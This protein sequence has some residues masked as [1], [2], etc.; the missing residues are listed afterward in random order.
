MCD[1]LD[2]NSEADWASRRTVRSL[3]STRRH[4]IEEAG[5]LA[6]QPHLRVSGQHSRPYFRSVRVR[7]HKPAEQRQ[8]ENPQI[9]QQTPVADVEQVVLQALLEAGVA[10]QAVDLG[11]AGD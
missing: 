5:E 1:T 8:P 9:E 3:Q 10:A 2:S 6:T 11:P 4:R 7:M